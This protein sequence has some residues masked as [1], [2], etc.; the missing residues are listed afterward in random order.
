VRSTL[1]PLTQGRGSK[2]LV[3]VP[4][5]PEQPSPLTQGRGSKQ[6]ERPYVVDGRRRPSRRGVDRN[7]KY[8][9]LHGKPTG[10]PSR[11]GVDRNLFARVGFLDRRGSPLTQGR[12]SKQRRR[13][14]REHG[15]QSPLT[16]G[17]GSKHVA[18][19]REPHT[20]GVAPHAGA[21]IE[22]TRRSRAFAPPR[23]SPLT[24]GRGSKRRHGRAHRL[25]RLVAPHAGAWIETRL[26]RRLLLALFVA[27]HAGAW[28][29]T[30]SRANMSAAGPK[31]PLTQGRGSKPPQPRLVDRQL[32]SPLTQGRGSK[33]FDRGMPRP[34]E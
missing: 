14:R 6:V 15:A 16:Q 12:G 23:M 13:Q 27:P 31:S 5:E 8:A 10:R 11:R 22:T 26:G 24:Q 9:G 29:E 19:H 2:P 25:E 7:Y 21:W 34:F 18:H 30:S 4:D 28:I 17:R 32:Q 3:V 33:Q 20:K 1:S